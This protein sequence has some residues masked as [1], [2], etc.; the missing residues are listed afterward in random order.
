[1]VHWIR[2]NFGFTVT[3]FNFTAIMIMIAMK[4]YSIHFTTSHMHINKLFTTL[5]ELKIQR[6]NHI[7]R[8]CVWHDLNPSHNNLY[9]LKTSIW[10]IGTTFHPYS[11]H[12][13]IFIVIIIYNIVN[14]HHAPQMS[15][16]FQLGLLANPRL[17][18]IHIS[19]AL[20]RFE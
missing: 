16:L 18:T 20:L 12:K 14:A 5:S 19:Y 11:C 6:Q 17:K 9:K 1:M 8:I 15:Y 10:N 4:L 13:A 7:F 3:V 2:I